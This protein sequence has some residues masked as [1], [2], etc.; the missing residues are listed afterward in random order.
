[1]WKRNT[2]NPEKFI[3]VFSITS[4]YCK[5]DLQNFIW[6]MAYWTSLVRFLLEK[7]PAALRYWFKFNPHEKI[8]YHKAPKQIAVQS[9]L[10]YQ[11]EIQLEE[12]V[13]ISVQ[14]HWI[15]SEKNPICNIHIIK[16]IV[17]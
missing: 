5:N 10:Y 9:L 16:C 12:F 7:T 14:R 13:N 11:L 2:K 3:K 1:M 15:K 4:D 8:K 17:W 6:P